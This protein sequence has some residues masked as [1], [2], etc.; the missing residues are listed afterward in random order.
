MVSCG[1]TADILCTGGALAK[2]AAQPTERIA[3]HKRAL[4]FRKLLASGP[5]QKSCNIFR[6]MFGEPLPHPLIGPRPL[7]GVGVEP[8]VLRPRGQHM[9]AHL[10]TTAPRAPLQV[11]VPE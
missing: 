11:A 1:T 5:G 2:A 9:L 7:K 3:Y 10:L 6:S 4:I 8:V